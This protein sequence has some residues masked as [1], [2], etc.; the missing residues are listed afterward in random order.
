MRPLIGVTNYYVDS[1]E[2]G[3]LE[4]RTRGFTG[5]DM[6]MCTMDY[7]RGI[8][9]AGGIPIMLSHIDD[10]EYLDNI[11]QRCDG[12]L[13]SGGA[14]VD[15]QLYGEEPIKECGAI[16]PKRD[17]FEIKLL[18]KVLKEDKPTFGI[19]RGMQLINIYYQGTLY[20]DLTAY[21]DQTNHHRGLKF[22][23]WYQIHEVK[24]EDNSQIA[25][26]FGKTEIKTN[27]LHHQVL[28]EV[29]EGLEVTAR[30]NDGIVEAIEDKSKQFLLA[31][32]WHPEMMFE[33]V[34]EQSK[35]FDYFVDNVKD[36]M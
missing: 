12:F 14:D 32:Q 24:L 2:L 20:Q 18:A 31:V 10:E 15:P 5:Q 6:A 23:K 30:A 17:S 28:K 21:N 26:A 22:P 36:L 29:G 3:A 7:L 27:S 25:Q 1:N 11:V 4:D 35:L 9:Q 16:T 13:F 34:A 19:C 8:R 33:K